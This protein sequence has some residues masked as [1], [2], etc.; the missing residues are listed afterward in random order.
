MIEKYSVVPYGIF[1]QI[2]LSVNLD[3]LRTLLFR[4][5]LV[6]NY[7]P[8]IDPESNDILWSF[9]IYDLSNIKLGIFIWKDDA[10]YHSYAE[11]VGNSI[12]F[13]KTK[14]KNIEI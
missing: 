4:E 2:D 13:I 1:N 5:E 9:E 11:A 12:N 8:L 6:F 7:Y 14:R 10:H 3:K